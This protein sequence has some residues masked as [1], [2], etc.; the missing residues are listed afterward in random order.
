MIYFNLFGQQDRH[1][2]SNRK[3]WLWSWSDFSLLFWYKYP[4][5]LSRVLQSIDWQW[6]LD[7]LGLVSNKSVLDRSV[8]VRMPF[9]DIISI[10]LEVSP[11]T[12][13]ET[14]G[15][16]PQIVEEN[17]LEGVNRSTMFTG[18]IVSTLG[19]TANHLAWFWIERNGFIRILNQ[20]QYLRHG[21]GT[22]CCKIAFPTTF[23]QG[24]S[25]PAL[26]KTKSD[27]FNRFLNTIRIL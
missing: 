20:K 24:Y 11:C 17:P 1:E 22:N 23:C 10:E 9:M 4:H 21:K 26:Y 14:L 27:T 18:W 13:P 25:Y 2:C 6:M 16:V 5:M 19:K 12:Y 7:V 8:S 15:C 3:M